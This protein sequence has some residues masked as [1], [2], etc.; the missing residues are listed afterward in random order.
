VKPDCRRHGEGPTSPL[1]GQGRGRWLQSGQSER[2]SIISGVRLHLCKVCLRKF[3]LDL[4]IRRVKTSSAPSQALSEETYLMVL[5]S[6]LIVSLSAVRSSS[7]W[8]SSLI[9]STPP[10]LDLRYRM[11]SNSY[12]CRSKLCLLCRSDNCVSVKSWGYF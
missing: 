3:G 4:Y 10:I 6:S 1:A 7:C 2:Q 11:P 9:F 5:L 12:S 8:K